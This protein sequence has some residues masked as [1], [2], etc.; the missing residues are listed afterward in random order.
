M[1]RYKR[2]FEENIINKKLLKEDF[3]ELEEF[4]KLDKLLYSCADDIIKMY[5][6]WAQRSE[7]IPQE[8]WK[9][10][11]YDDF[12]DASNQCKNELKY[13]VEDTLHMRLS[14]FLN[15]I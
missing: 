2:K 14:S 8:E 4:K 6:T 10:R 5:K 7:D 3:I 9:D 1:E 12:E 13:H 11:G 15:R